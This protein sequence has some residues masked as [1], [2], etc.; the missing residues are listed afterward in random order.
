MTQISQN[1]E[2]A[3]KASETWKAAFNSGDAKGCAE[4]YEKD[5]TMEAKPFGTFNGRAEIESFWAKI[6]ADGFSDIE[7]ID[8][9][10]ESLD[11]S[12]AHLSAKW[13]MNKAH[14]IIT[15]EIWVLQEDGTA[16][17]RDDAF[18]VLG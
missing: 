12:K 1:I 17:L 5:A 4:C 2:A 7:Y 15:K 18:E 16:L 10:I 9:V 11:D 13:K 14:G 8:P 6:I 3:K